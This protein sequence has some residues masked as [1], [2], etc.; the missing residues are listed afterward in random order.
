MATSIP[1]PPTRQWVPGATNP[2]SAGAEA[3]LE[4]LL[5]RPAVTGA[6]PTAPAASVATGPLARAGQWMAG[7][8]G[9]KGALGRAS[10]PVGA[11]MIAGPPIYQWQREHLPFVEDISPAGGVLDQA[12]LGNLGQ[13]VLPIPGTIGAVSNVVAGLF[14]R[15]RGSD[16]VQAESG[17][18]GP[19][20]EFKSAAVR[21]ALSPLATIPITVSKAVEAGLLP[22]GTTPDKYLG[23]YNVLKSMGD[24]SPE[25]N[26]AIEAQVNEL[27]NQD[28]NS[29]GGVSPQDMLTQQAYV[30]KTIQPMMESLQANNATRTGALMDLVNTLPQEYQQLTRVG[31]A[32]QALANDALISAYAA[33]AA[34][35]PQSAAI[36][37]GIQQSQSIANQLQQ[38][39]ISNLLYPPTPATSSSDSLSALLAQQGGG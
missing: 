6:A 11:A 4:S 5:A 14:G 16:D 27:I 10:L 34:L 9:M 20:G 17:S 7:G 13:G 24:G 18:G 29:G 2:T 26:A 38:Q 39:A 35:A 36:E 28:M 1:V 22:P 21:A 8:Q 31:L 37:Q 3:A 23:Y 12:T 19:K 33:Q 15:G 25:S 32:D 30:A